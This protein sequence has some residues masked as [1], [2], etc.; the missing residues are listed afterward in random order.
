MKTD[1]SIETLS[2]QPPPGLASAHIQTILPFLLGKGGEESPSAPFLVQLE[3]GDS[4]FCKMS[5]PPEWKQHQKTILL[6]HGLGGSDSS[7]YMIRMSRKL[8]Q[9]GYRVLRLN[10]RGS[11]QGIH[12][13]QRPYHAGLSHDILQVI[14]ILKKQ[15]PE[16]PLV[17]I[18]FSLGGNVVLKLL[19][20]LGERAVPLVEK[21]ITICVPIDLAQTMEFLSQPFNQLYH[22]YYVSRLREIG[23]RWIGKQTIRSILDF[24]N[25]VTASQWGY[26]D[27]FDYYSQ[28]SSLSF[29][30]SICQTCHLIFSEDD[31]FVNCRLVIERSLSSRVKIWISKHGGHMGFW[32]WAGKEHGYSWL[33]S[34]LLKLVDE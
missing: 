2:F 11:G 23:S 13:A 33:D 5:T 6:L 25:L 31:P 12:F 26:S 27:A 32:G 17:L 21:A 10:L 4:I 34:L 30:P 24:D 20:E 1:C 22:Y 8:Y 14:H 7:D 9:A 15:I 18:G 19:G 3:D 29:L 16:S 28:C